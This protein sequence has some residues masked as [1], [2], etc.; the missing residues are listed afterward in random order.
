MKR[1]TSGSGPDLVLVH[2]WAMHSGM[3]G[4]FSEQLA[5]HWT[6]HALELPGHGGL[7]AVPAW[8]PSEVA[9]T[10]LKRVPNAR[11]LAWSLGGQ[12]ALEAVRQAPASVRGLV[13]LGFNPCFIARSDWPYGIRKRLFDDLERRCEADYLATIKG[14][15]K[16]Q[17]AD[18]EH[19]LGVARELQRRFMAGPVPERLSVL[20]G[21]ELLRQGDYRRQLETVSVPTLWI[22]GEQDAICPAASGAAGAALMPDARL[23]TIAGAGHAAFISHPDAIVDAMLEFN[24][25]AAPV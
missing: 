22:N 19:A 10:V 12:V 25:Q 20:R 2:G 1:H 14:F 3:F 13:L 21:L 4:A 16:L 18:S 17:A 23:R 11:W 7:P 9:A 5:R 24:P 15:L 6:V 8:T